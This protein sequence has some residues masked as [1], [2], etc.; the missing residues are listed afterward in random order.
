MRR[1]K[2]QRP[3]DVGSAQAASGGSLQIIMV[4]RAQHD[5]RGRHIKNLRRKLEQAGAGTEC[6]RSVYGVGYRFEV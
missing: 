5:L 2:L 3:L 4:G 1:T 6:I